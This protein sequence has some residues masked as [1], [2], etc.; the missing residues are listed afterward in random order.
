[1]KRL[2]RAPLFAATLV[3]MLGIIAG[4]CGD[5]GQDEASSTLQVT[6]DGTDCTYSGPEEVSESDIGVRVDNRSE[7]AV[8]LDVFRLQEGNTFDDLVAHIGAGSAETPTWARL[9]GSMPTSAG[10]TANFGMA[11]SAGN[12]A[13][14][15]ST[16]LPRPQM[17]AVAAFTVVV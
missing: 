14:V 2:L 13:L 1:M 5:D 17:Q 3:V 4:A 15:C 6:F 8:T 16:D 7:E 12:Y 11:L 10:E 9:V